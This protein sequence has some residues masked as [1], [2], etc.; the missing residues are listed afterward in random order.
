MLCRKKT[1]SRYLPVNAILHVY[2]S[3]NVVL[4]K[5]NIIA[6][7]NSSMQRVTAVTAY[8]NNKKLLPFALTQQC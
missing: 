3:N 5:R 6:I 8:L 7:S 1:R 2:T 4:H